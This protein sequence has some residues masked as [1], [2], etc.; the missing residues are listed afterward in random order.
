MGGGRSRI[1]SGMCVGDGDECVT[2]KVIERLW[3][4]GHED[5]GKYIYG[6]CMYSIFVEVWKRKGW[7][8]LRG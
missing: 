2:L 6:T 5:I 1:Y 8:L 4:A 7:C 3:W